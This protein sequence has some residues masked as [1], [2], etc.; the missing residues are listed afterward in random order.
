MTDKLRHLLDS[1]VEFERTRQPS[2]V[3]ILD[4]FGAALNR[5]FASLGVELDDHAARAALVA[6][7]CLPPEERTMNQLVVAMCI[8]RHV[9]RSDG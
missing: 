4:Q 8:A 9:K 3:A 1:L 5:Q 7:T 6:F 2:E